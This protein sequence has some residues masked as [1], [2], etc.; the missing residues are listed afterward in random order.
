MLRAYL[1]IPRDRD[2]S[3]DPATTGIPGDHRDHGHVPGTAGA[4]PKLED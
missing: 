4:G 2:M 1:M 3:A